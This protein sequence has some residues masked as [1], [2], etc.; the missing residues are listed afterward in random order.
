MINNH[1]LIFDLKEVNLLKRYE[2]ININRHI[3][4]EKWNNE[5]DN[6]FFMFINGN[7]ILFELNEDNN[8]NIDLKVI[9][10][11]YCPNFDNIKKLNEKNNKF[12]SIDF[13]N[14]S[15]SIY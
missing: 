15:I 2:I 10:Q 8:E 7:L 12:Y 13:I 11:L 3:Q 9:S 4:I 5:E 6:E 14:N 1:I